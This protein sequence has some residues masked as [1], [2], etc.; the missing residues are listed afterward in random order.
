VNVLIALS[1]AVVKSILVA[2][3]FM[4][5]K[6][7]NPLHSIIFLFCLFALA[8]FLFFAMTDLGAGGGLHVQVRRDP[9]GRA[10]DRHPGEG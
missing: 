8:L 1:I 9:A 2:M 4:Q 6:Y 10:G 7:D 5:L 3:F